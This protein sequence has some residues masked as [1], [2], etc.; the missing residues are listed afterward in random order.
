GSSA[1]RGASRDPLPAR[2]ARRPLEGPEPGRHVARAPGS[3]RL[4]LRGDGAGH[5][6]VSADVGLT[7]APSVSPLRVEPPPPSSA[8]QG[9]SWSPLLPCE[10]GEVDRRGT[11]RD[12]G[13]GVPFRGGA[14]YSPPSLQVRFGTFPP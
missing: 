1:R 2:G 12:G 14:A 6:A 11:R 10:A 13:G 4:R 8:G 3:A 7:S 5:G 9:R